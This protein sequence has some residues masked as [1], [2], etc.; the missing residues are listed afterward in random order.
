MIWNGSRFYIGEILDIYKKGSNSR[1]GSVTS[2]TTVAGLSYLSLRVY[3]PLVTVGF[4]FHLICNSLTLTSK[5]TEDSDSESEDDC[6][7]T[8][9]PGPAPLFSCFSKDAHIHTHAQIDHLIFNL[10]R[11]IFVKGDDLHRAL[12]PQAALRWSTLT[13][14]PS[15]KKEVKKVSLKLMIPGGKG[16]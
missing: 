2:A 13:K 1:H 14:K 4:P 3:L 9:I 16:K 11:L 10:G 12:T 7:P 15:V 8:R 5:V 6:D